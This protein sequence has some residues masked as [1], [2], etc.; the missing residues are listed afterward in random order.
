MGG[1]EGG[2]GGGEKKRKEREERKRDRK[3]ERQKEKEGERET[4]PS[5]PCLLFSLDNDS[6]N[7]RRDLAYKVKSPESLTAFC[8]QILKTH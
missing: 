2:G 7:A 6:A 5:N 4:F 3:R 1:G 8:A